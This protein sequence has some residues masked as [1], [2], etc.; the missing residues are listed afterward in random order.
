MF[1]KNKKMLRKLSHLA[2]EKFKNKFT[3]KDSSM[4]LYRVI[5]E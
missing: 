5:N 2:C 4:K 1:Y 3:V